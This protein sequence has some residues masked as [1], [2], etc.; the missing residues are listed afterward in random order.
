MVEEAEKSG[1]LTKDPQPTT[2]I[3]PTS[4]NTGTNRHEL[5]MSNF[6]RDRLGIGRCCQGISCGDYTP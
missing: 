5:M 2:I 1:V 4:G 3:E 6:R